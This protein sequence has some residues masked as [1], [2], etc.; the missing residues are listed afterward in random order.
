MSDLNEAVWQT[1]PCC[2]VGESKP[3]VSVISPPRRR[4]PHQ[5]K[6]AHVTHTKSAS[7]PHGRSPLTRTLSA[8]NMLWYSRRWVLAAR[9]KLQVDPLAAICRSATRPQLTSRWHGYQ[10]RIGGRA[11]LVFGVAVDAVHAI[12]AVA[13]QRL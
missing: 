2:N 10:A 13:H 7:T 6:P 9:R 8:M 4:P 12:A 5:A 1:A 11:L 3:Q